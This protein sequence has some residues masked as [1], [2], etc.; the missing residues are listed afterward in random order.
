M[1]AEAGAC[2]R[3]VK[4]RLCFRAGVCSLRKAALASSSAAMSPAAQK[5]RETVPNGNSLGILKTPSNN[6]AR[7]LHCYS[8]REKAA[9]LPGGKG[10]RC[11]LAPAACSL[12]HK[13][14]QLHTTGKPL[15][16][17]TRDCAL[18]AL[19][20]QTDL[21]DRVPDRPASGSGA[22]TI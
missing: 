4:L 18:A 5:I 3:E 14:T 11:C 21:Q 20:S 19:L 7:G 12:R 10:E 16:Y 22:R 17:L 8:T 15:N 2:R 6:S 9:A 13:P 1:A